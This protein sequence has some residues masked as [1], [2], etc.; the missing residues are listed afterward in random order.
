MEIGA[1]P[2]LGGR[3]LQ[4]QPSDGLLDE[5]KD[6]DRDRHRLRVITGSHMH[7]SKSR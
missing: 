3:L 7:W 2:Q 5:E 4:Q 6:G 1:L